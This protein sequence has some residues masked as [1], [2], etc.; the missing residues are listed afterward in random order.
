[1]RGDREMNA[2]RDCLSDCGLE[3][4][5]YRGCAFT[6]RR[7]NSPNIHV[8]ERLDRFLAMTHGLICT[9]ILVFNISL[10]IHQI[11]APSFL[12]YC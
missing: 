2:F 6:W 9:L 4:L 7:G 8:M 12:I 10:S 3:D 5:G 1:M 11:I